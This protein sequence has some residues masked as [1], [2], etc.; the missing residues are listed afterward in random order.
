ME[1]LALEQRATEDSDR[2]LGMVY[3][4]SVHRRPVTR[5]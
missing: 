5:T 3:L 4:N 1:I 2:M